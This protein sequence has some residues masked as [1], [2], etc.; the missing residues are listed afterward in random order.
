MKTLP[1]IAMVL[2]FAGCYG[3][4][5][6]V[7]NDAAIAVEPGLTD[8]P[9]GVLTVPPD[10]ILDDFD[11]KYSGDAQ[12]WGTQWTRDHSAIEMDGQRAIELLEMACYADVICHP[13]EYPLR[14]A[15][16]DYVRENLDNPGLR[17]AIRWIR[18]AYKSGLPLDAPGDESGVFKG[19]LVQSMKIRMTAY[20]NELLESVDVKGDRD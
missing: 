10:A 9:Y 5:Q 14:V 3:Q 19:V 6:S 11:T 4:P 18:S 16:L 8:S 15:T 12:Q 20:A 17:D 13:V 2:L 7:S 1:P